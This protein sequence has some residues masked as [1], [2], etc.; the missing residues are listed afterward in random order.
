MVTGI[1]LII[2]TLLRVPSAIVSG[3]N[4]ARIKAHGGLEFGKTNSR[5]LIVVQFLIYLST[6]GYAIVE[7]VPVG[8]HTYIGLVVYARDGGA[9]LCHPYA[10]TLLDLQN[11][12]CQGPPIDRN[13]AIQARQASQL[14]LEHDPGGAQLR[15]HFAGLGRVYPT[16][17]AP[18]DHVVQPDSTGGEGHEEEVPGGQV[19]L[20]T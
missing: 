6:I 20:S 3:R 19:R 18:S 4:E 15:N 16:V 12:Y 5:A 14:L 9:H 7:D 1:I 2:L 13:S 8:V 11:L 17:R 10:G